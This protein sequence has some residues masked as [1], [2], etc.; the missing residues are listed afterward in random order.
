MYML[1]CK[2][3]KLFS[4]NAPLHM[5]NRS[6]HSP[7]K[8]LRLLLFSEDLKSWLS[9]EKSYTRGRITWPK[10]SFGDQREDSLVKCS[11]LFSL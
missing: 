11:N 7:L 5:Q 10:N 2:T 8:T 9:A 1:E 3:P 4:F 6:Y